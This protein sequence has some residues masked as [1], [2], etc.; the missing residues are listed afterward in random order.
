MVASNFQSVGLS[1]FCFTST[2]DE[3]AVPSE[4]QAVRSESR[5]SHSAHLKPGRKQAERARETAK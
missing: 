5:D 1:E 4:L 2:N 3:T